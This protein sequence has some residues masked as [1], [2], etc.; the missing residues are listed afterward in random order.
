MAED[1]RKPRRGFS[2]KSPIRGHVRPL[3]GTNRTEERIWTQI[4]EKITVLYIYNPFA[5][6]IYTTCAVCNTKI[7]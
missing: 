3:Y 6:S 7:K 1:G 2:Q 4:N 5:K